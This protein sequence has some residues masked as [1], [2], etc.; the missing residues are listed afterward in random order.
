MQWT[1]FITNFLEGSAAPLL[2]F[3]MYL[4]PVSFAAALGLLYWNV[5][6]PLRY[7]DSPERHSQNLARLRRHNDLR[8]FL[9]LSSTLSGLWLC[10]L[11]SHQN[12]SDLLFLLFFATVL[13]IASSVLTL[14]NRWRGG[15]YTLLMAVHTLL[16]YAFLIFANI[17][18]AAATID[19]HDSRLLTVV[20][21]VT[22]L[23][24][25]PTEMIFGKLVLFTLKQRAPV[26]KKAL[27]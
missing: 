15:R 11:P 1:R 6:L 25:F 18:P 13:A 19:L 22:A 26:Q 14:H 2:L 27:K 24:L 3:Y 21:Y 8:I 23:V 9:F 16:F 7:H 17:V 5:R 4:L 12:G 10:V 20:L